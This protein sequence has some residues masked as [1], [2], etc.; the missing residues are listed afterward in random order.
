MGFSQPLEQLIYPTPTQLSRGPWSP[1]CCVQQ[2]P[3]KL[4]QGQRATP[5]MPWARGHSTKTK[6][7]GVAFPQ[8]V[9][10]HS[11]PSGEP[12]PSSFIWSQR[13][14][15]Q[16]WKS[17]VSPGFEGLGSCP[18][19]IPFIKVEKPTLKHIAAHRVLS[20]DRYSHDFYTPSR[21]RHSAK[22]FT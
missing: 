18:R 7:L 3:P 5:Q 10:G 16:A 21:A 13:G 2:N 14:W 22:D 11:G 19:P 1:C 9:G 17:M 4:L 8:G 12:H 15:G 20:S 6:T